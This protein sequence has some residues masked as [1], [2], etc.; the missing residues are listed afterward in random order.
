M[1]VSGQGWDQ[2]RPGRPGPLHGSLGPVR[3]HRL[4]SSGGPRFTVLHPRLKSLADFEQEPCISVLPWAL[5]IPLFK[6]ELLPRALSSHPLQRWPPI[7]PSG[8]RV[9]APDSDP[10]RANVSAKM[11]AQSDKPPGLCTREG[12]ALP[13]TCWRT[14]PPAGP[15]GA[16]PQSLTVHL[17]KQTTVSVFP[18]A[19]PLHLLPGTARVT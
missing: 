17:E 6:M 16:L 13:L 15:V 3:L 7:P 2:G 12:N 5:H 19:R 4:P 18:Q 9:G 11:N 10:A 1:K 14:R 8:G